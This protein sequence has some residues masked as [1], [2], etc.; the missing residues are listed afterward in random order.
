MKK[1][2][3][4]IEEAI[5]QA[6]VKCLPCE[7]I[8]LDYHS[9]SEY[10]D[11]DEHRAE[12]L[13]EYPLP[14]D[15]KIRILE[16]SKDIPS[17][18]KYFLDGS[19]RTYK[20]ADLLVKGRYLPLVAGQV[21]V[22]VVNRDGFM[23]IKPY[24]DLCHTVNVLA[25][26]DQV[27]SEADASDLESLIK[28]DAGVNLKVLRY[29][30]KDDRDPVDLAIAKIMSHMAD[31]E[32]ST[33]HKLSDKYAL[34]PTSLLVKDGPLR[35]KNI[36]GRGFDITQFRNVIGLSK[37]FQPS[38]ALG[39]GRSK[40]DVGVITS[41]L[42]YGERTP[43]FKTLEEDKYI[44]MWYMRIRQKEKMANPLQGIIKIESYAIGQEEEER[45]LDSERVDTISSHLLRERNVT[46]YGQ[47]SR[48]AT[49]IYPIYQAE[50]FIKV[51][52]L[53]DIHF[54]ALF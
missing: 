24:R 3:N 41:S 11:S 35:Y 15:Q 28:K 37:T 45:G 50:T 33:V 19:R 29:K 40:K 34:Q 26:P 49:H 27:T 31:L 14:D 17:I 21:G 46:P 42:E 39:K 12:D 6:D 22:A 1:I 18:L 36:K 7:R 53:S 32:L 9:F 5:E 52:M 10:V 13:F 47:D 4:S 23:K 54:K 48:W 38:F 30:V 2:I 20:V 43:V 8:N 44:G 25:F 51:S 16:T